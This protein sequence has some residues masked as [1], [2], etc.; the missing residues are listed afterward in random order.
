MSEATKEHIV[1]DN[2]FNYIEREDDDKPE[3][4]GNMRTYW[5]IGRSTGLGGSGGGADGA[6]H[7][8]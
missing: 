6:A 2:T 8:K 3:K 4:L 7:E 1:R 5:L